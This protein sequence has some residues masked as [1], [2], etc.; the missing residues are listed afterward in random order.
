M[1]P[2]FAPVP[3]RGAL[4]A[5][6]AQQIAQEFAGAGVASPAHVARMVGAYLARLAMQRPKPAATLAGYG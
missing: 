5:F 4:T 1:P 6:L 3:M 2:A